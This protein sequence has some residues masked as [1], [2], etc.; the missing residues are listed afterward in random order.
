MIAEAGWSS[1]TP[2]CEAAQ[3]GVPGGEKT[4]ICA[5]LMGIPAP[6][7]GR[8]AVMT[9]TEF[10]D[11]DDHCRHPVHGLGTCCKHGETISRKSGGG[12]GARATGTEDPI[13]ALSDEAHN[14]SEALGSKHTIQPSQWEG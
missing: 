13:C 12:G 3:M 6:L 5:V 2:L 1:S 9:G 7:V 11:T 14:W 10:V 4:H 8:A